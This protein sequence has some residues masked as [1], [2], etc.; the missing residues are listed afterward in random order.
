MADIIF[1]LNRAG[2]DQDLQIVAWG[3]NLAH[4]LFL[5]DL[6]AK[7]SFYI[8][9]VGKKLKEEECMWNYMKFKS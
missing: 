1:L 5:Y 2:L 8:L 9:K 7:D 6:H 3:T 4:H